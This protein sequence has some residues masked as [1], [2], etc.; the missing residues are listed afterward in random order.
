MLIETPYKV[1]R[2]PV[3]ARNM[4]AT[5]QPLA[6]QAGLR[7]LDRGGNAIDAALATAICLT[8]V[9]PTGN[10]LGSD[11]F[12]ILW[13]G[14]ALHGLNASGRSPAAW[15]EDRFGDGPM[16]KRGWE[17]VT[18]PGAVS[19]WVALSE[20]FGK[21]PFADLFGPAIRHA[22][23]G[24]PVSPTIAGLWAKGAALLGDQPGFADCFM[25]GGRAPQAGEIF[26]NPDLARSL[27]MIAESHGAA[28][29]T[30]ELAQ[31][32]AAAAASNGA[33]LSEADLA[34]HQVDWCGTISVP[35]GDYELHE[36]P[37]NG[38]GIAAL[39]ALGAIDR[40]GI[41]DLSPD[42]PQAIHLQIEAI[43][44]G[45][46]DAAAHVADPVAMRMGAQALLDPAYL[47]T[48]A[49]LISSSEARDPQ[50]GA[51]TA[52]GTVYIT[53]ADADGRM[54]SYIQSNYMGFG[55]GVVVPGTGIHMQNR[56]VGFVTTPGHPNR[57]GPSKRPFHT[58][59][60]GFA[61]RDG[62]P[63][64]SFGVMGGPMQAQGHLQMFLRTML[65]GQSPQAASDA[66]R[67][68]LMQGRTVAVEADMP[69]A[70]MEALRALGHDI[71][72]EGPEAVFGFGGAQLI[73]RLEG[74]GYI[75]G[76]DHRKDGMA[77][78]V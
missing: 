70:T 25:P 76:S 64:M 22:R 46:A 41:R 74:G 6:V 13:D 54:V 40:T 31:A 42:D 68:Q 45:L 28:F 71:V 59:I 50:A 77:A 43:K 14:E 36:I 17:A 63:E 72:R 7:M 53:A 26:R 55:A 29:Y 47:D 8:V 39:M 34:A 5:S 12:S 60:P 58:I 3:M 35:F 62:A 48:R 15:T 57:V 49:A 24:F 2:V 20:R 69:A 78:G 52:G 65:W 37:P 19:A 33:A 56:A 66:P 51:P 27:E 18:T 4:V 67:W 30:G 32:I 23:D 1:R 9:E 16:P 10:G 61:T 73:R 44:L 75:G 11:A 38:Q 21:L